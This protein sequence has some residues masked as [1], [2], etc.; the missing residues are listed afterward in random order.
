[1]QSVGAVV[2]DLAGEYRPG[3][4][5]PEEHRFIIKPVAHSTPEAFDEPF[6]RR[7]ARLDETP[8]DADL[9]TPGQHCVQLQFD[10]IADNDS[11]YAAP[12][13]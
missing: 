1:M 3:L 13:Y 6:L 10:F 2:I 9:D 11:G 8:F 7:L 12:D 4:A 5:S